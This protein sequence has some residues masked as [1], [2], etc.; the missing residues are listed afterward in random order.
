MAEQQP[1]N[2]RL[3]A[4]L[5]G[6]VAVAMLVFLTTGGDLGGVKKVESDADL[7]KIVSPTTPK[8][9]DNTGTR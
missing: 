7:P 1:A 2:S 4:L 8:D 9:A 6:I 3:I 5:G